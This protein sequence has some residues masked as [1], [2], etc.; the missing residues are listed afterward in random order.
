M[1][2]FDVFLNSERLYT[3]GVGEAGVMT[4]CVTWVL[5]TA[6]GVSSPS[7]LT[8]NVGGM[9]HDAHH[10]WPAPRHLK[11]GDEVT[12]RILETAHPDPPSSTKRD[13]AALVEREE[14]KYYRRLKAKYEL[15]E[16][17]RSSRT[18]PKRREGRRRTTRCS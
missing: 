11:V 10:H 17:G 15:N 3:A 6:P 5:R 2:G 7:E 16:A 4:A 12:V 9:S 18:Q 13:D 1:I 14:R 8:L